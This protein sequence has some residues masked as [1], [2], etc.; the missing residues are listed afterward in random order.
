MILQGSSLVGKI[1]AQGC[2]SARINIGG[3]LLGTVVHAIGYTDYTGAYEVTPKVTEQSL[4]TKDKHMT[5]DVT[6]KSIPFFNVSNTSGG[7]TAY[8][9]SEV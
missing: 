8:I 2:L 9:G 5:D 7:S 3:S 4:K 6:I 1:T